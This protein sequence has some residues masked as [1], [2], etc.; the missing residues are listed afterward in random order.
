M[1]QP[2]LVLL[3]GDTLDNAGVCK[4]YIKDVIF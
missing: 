3:N 4:K 1:A 2:D